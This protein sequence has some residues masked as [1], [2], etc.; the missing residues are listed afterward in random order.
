MTDEDFDKVD[1][2]FASEFDFVDAN[3]GSGPASPQGAGPGPQAPK[4]SP[5]I[6][7][8][9]VLIS[10]L[11]GGYYAYNRF[12]ASKGPKPPPEETQEKTAS[13]TAAKHELPTLPAHGMPASG[14]GAAQTPPAPPGAPGA[15]TADH[16]TAGEVAEAL[17]PSN[18]E[19]TAALPP[20]GGGEKSFDQLQKELHTAQ[21]QAQTAQQS[22]PVEV[23]TAL[24]HISE[25]MTE[26]AN[27]IHQLET[28][29]SNMANTL[30]ALNKTISAM[31][32]RIVSVSEN[33]DGLSQDLANVKRVM[34]DQDLDLTM[35]GNVKISSKK[36][37]HAI[38]ST[39]PNYSVHAIIPGRA[40]L[41]GGNG[42]IITVT[43][44]DRVGDYG[45]VAVIDAANGLVRTSSG[46]MIK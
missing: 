15:P 19:L 46:I 10:I 23:R 39:E 42:Q 34:V 33:V 36:Q 26:N 41:K 28:T 9:L 25:E 22:V 31:D 17:K 13:T 12:F 5:A 35:P 1:E 16:K 4:G 43:E 6:V 20:A 2:D 37:N 27:N 18:N 30:D 45:T 11:G 44:G 21:Q 40:W 38:S 8:L 29:I 24:Q 3:K 32:N 7:S 14:P